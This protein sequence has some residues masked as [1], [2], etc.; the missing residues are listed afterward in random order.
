M[1]QS[2]LVARLQKTIPNVQLT[3]GYVKR[4][5]HIDELEFIAM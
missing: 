5:F 2:V 3:Q 4:T 1:N